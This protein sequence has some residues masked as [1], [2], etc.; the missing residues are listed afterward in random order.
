VKERKDA[1]ETRPPAK[2]YDLDDLVKR[3]KPDNVHDL[4]DF[5]PP[6]GKE[7]W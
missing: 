3:I 5:G 2:V 6:K 4:I 1:V 7:A